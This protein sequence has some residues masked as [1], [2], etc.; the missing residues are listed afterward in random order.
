ME[1]FTLEEA[2]RWVGRPVIA[3][4]AFETNV[5]LIQAEEQGTVIGVDA[6]DSPAGAPLVRLAVEFRAPDA[7]PTVILV[8]KSTFTTYL[9]LSHTVES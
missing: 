4:A 7:P 9:C 6:H 2:Q 5:T 1:H 3:K 8:T